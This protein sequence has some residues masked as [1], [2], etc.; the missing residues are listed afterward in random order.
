M[1]ARLSS[2]VSDRYLIE[3]ELGR[4]GMATV[5]L[6]QDRRHDR[7]VALKVLKP[8]LAAVLG[9]ERFV[10][11]IKTTAALQHPHILPLFDSGTADGFLY[12]VMPYIQ[13]ETLRGKLD[14]ET[15]LG[16]EESVRITTNVADALDYAHRHGVIHRDIKPENIL[17]HDGRPMVA[18]FG[19]A[20]ALSAAAGGRMTETGMSLGTPHYMSPEQATAD[21][22]ISGRS[23]IYSLGSVLYEMLTGNPPHTGSSAQQIIMKIVT[24][25]AAPVTKLRRAVPPNVAAAVA[26]ALEKLPADRFDSAQSFARAL[27][28]RAYRPA[29]ATARWSVRTIVLTGAVT[30]ACALAVVAVSAAWVNRRAAP[31]PSPGRVQ[32]VVT[33]KGAAEP[34]YTL[35]WPAVVSPDGRAIVYAGAAGNGT[36][37]YYLRDAGQLDSH[38]IP[39]TIE[40]S[41]PT[42]S[43]DGRWVAFQAQDG[44][45]KKARLDGS[46]PIALAEYHQG[47]GMAWSPRGVIVLGAG[48]KWLGLSRMSE[49]GGALAP[50]TTPDSAHAGW[51]IWPVVLADGRTIVFSVWNSMDPTQG[52]EL[53]FTS[54]DDPVVHLTGLHAL[55][56]LGASGEYLVYIAADGVVMATR[57]NFRNRHAVGSSVALI[58]SIPVCPV[59]NGDAAVSLSAGGALAYMRG[60]PRRRLV[61]VNRDGT[62]TNAGPDAALILTPRISPDGSRIAA[63]I[64]AAGRK[65]IWVYQIATRTM[66]RITTDGDNSA[67]AWGADGRSILFLSARAGRTAFVR[68]PLDASAD[69]APILSGI[70]GLEWGA[71]L[72]PDERHVIRQSSTGATISLVTA[73]VGGDSQRTFVSGNYNAWGARFSPSGRSV[74]YASDESGRTEVYI[75]SFPGPG[76]RVQVS[77]G[78]GSEP[79]WSRDG[80]RLYYAAGNQM[81]SAT[82]APE[83]N[84]SVVTRDSLFSAPF[85]GTY[86]TPATYDVGPDGRL[87]V[88][89]PD[90]AHLQLVVALNWTSDLGARVAAPTP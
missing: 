62:E 74:A 79:V 26:R 33:A 1:G 24:E 41:L 22:E 45:V 73:A 55:R 76:V 36:Y 39:G 61:W 68:Q 9:A 65:D 64:D 58:D 10:Q 77:A 35:T 48:S 75:R 80:L 30:L 90:E 19:I 38:A 81:T 13:G 51:H 72:S 88:L 32:F 86:L 49:N 43:P 46:A 66:T 6:A 57:F 23:D 85:F 56:A 54:L 69:A 87:L 11:E 50:L 12:Y 34:V 52:S 4:G 44:R 83:P 25:E 37:Q 31:D 17:L 53:A 21:K 27:N 15:Q 28:D 40:A 84:V 60:G 63:E 8:E 5:Y 47:N 67:P 82:L 18:D 71:A 16:I 29:R 78:G 89:K 7:L 70:E 59:C 42:F 3:R 20:L 2:A 14:R